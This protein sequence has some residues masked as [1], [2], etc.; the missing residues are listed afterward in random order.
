MQSKKKTNLSIL[1]IKLEIQK[2]GICTFL[3]LKA[4]LGKEAR[5]LPTLKGTPAFLIPTAY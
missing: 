4:D 1:M 5:T 3:L 2:A